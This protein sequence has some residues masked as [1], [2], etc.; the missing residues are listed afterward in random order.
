MSI[1]ERPA[2]RRLASVKH[3]P[4]VLRRTQEERSAT[5]RHRL[6]QAAI[7]TICDC[8]FAEATV[9]RIAS[10]ADL[11]RGAV[12]HHFGTRNDLLIAVI[13]DFAKELFSRSGD[14]YAKGRAIEQR[15]GAICD[16]YWGIVGSRHFIAVIQVLLG[17][18]NDPAVYRNLLDKMQWFESEL[19]RKWVD[20]FRDLAVP[21]ARL[22]VARHVVL[23]TLRGLA[24]R[25]VYRMDN[26]RWAAE[27]ELL[28]EILAYALAGSSGTSNSS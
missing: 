8:G 6:V 7:D 12:Q 10:R 18:R 28:K 22:A 27:R 19:D 9:A 2:A 26:T 5:T 15:V 25:M 24:I 21:T 4:R 14:S 13:D 17:V 11:T 23:A 3:P 16:S 20:L 1:D